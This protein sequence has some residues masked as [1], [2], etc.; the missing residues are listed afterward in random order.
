MH[1]VLFTVG[2]V[3]IYSYG[4]MLVTCV[5]AGVWLA[6]R[7]A[8]RLPPERRALAADRIADWAAAVLLGG[9]LGGRVLYVALHW[10]LFAAAPLQAFAIWRGGLVWYGG[11]AGGA[12]GAWLYLRA[13]R[14]PFLQAADQ[15]IPFVALSHAIGRVGCFLN[16]CCYGRPTEAWYGVQ[17]PGQPGPVI[18][19]QLLEAVGLVALFVFLRSARR[20]PALQRP[21]QVFGL[22]LLGYAALR[23]LVETLRGDQP[24]WHALTLPQLVSLS[25]VLVGLSLLKRGQT[26]CTRGLTPFR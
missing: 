13:H 10:P 18:P 24:R 9:I 23:F 22:Y 6:C 11:F 1:P 8:G 20:W 16:G 15:L 14:V 21:G 26:P 25:L 2:P 12:L 4:V 5:L 17:F 19:T 3:T 7:D